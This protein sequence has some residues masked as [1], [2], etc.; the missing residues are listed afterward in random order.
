MSDRTSRAIVCGAGIAGISAAYHLAVRHDMRDVLLVDERAPLSVTSDK[1]TECYRNWWPGPGDAMVRFMNRSIDIMEELARESDNCFHLGRKG[2]LFVTADP[3]RIPDFE[4]AAEEPCAL[5]AGPLRIHT[6]EPGDPIYTPAPATGFENLPTGADLI[7]DPLLIREHFPFLSTDVIAALHTR[8][9]GRLSAQQMGMYMLERAREA[10]LQFLEARVEGVEVR[11]GRVR[12]V[13]LRDASGSRTV[14]T[15]VFVNAA[16]PFVKEV[17]RMVGVDLPV[18]CELHTKIAYNDRLSTIPQSAPLYYW[19]DGQRLPWSE[20][21]RAL[22]AESEEMQW[23]LAPFPPGPHG[24]PEGTPGSQNQLC[25]WTYDVE[26]VEPVL[27]LPPH[28][29]HYFEVVL[30]GLSRMIPGLQAYFDRLPQPVV[31][32]GYYTKTGENRP[33]IGPLPVEGAYII[34]ALSGFGIMAGCAAGELL[35]AHVTGSGV[36]SYA[37]WFLLERYEDPDYRALLDDWDESG[38]L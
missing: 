26:T 17:A 34:G 31:D 2:Y 22:L 23:L 12:G 33:L 3:A 1:S 30:R 8:R 16:G 10:G 24:L 18:Y 38:Q 4:R 36:P 32:G 20:E 25:L 6:G 11:A 27:P 21:E 15:E 13:H 19:A 29:P 28:D 7:L 5:G 14:G 35:S 37:P 9:C